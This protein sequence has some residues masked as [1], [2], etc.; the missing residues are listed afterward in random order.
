MKHI[1]LFL[2][3]LLMVALAIVQLPLIKADLGTYKVNTCVNIRVL[4]NCSS[5]NLT[6]VSNRNNT[7]IINK[8]MTNI[9]GQTFNY[10]FCNTSEVDTYTYSWNPSCYDCANGNCGNSFNITPSGFSNLT[11]FYFIILLLGFGIMILG[12]WIQDGWTV[13]LG[14]IGLY[15]VGLLILIQGIDFIKDGFVTMGI[16]SVVLGLAAYISINSAIEILG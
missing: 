4:A 8:A 12:F 6:E 5:V 2:M 7:F 10:T 14:T 16:G 3:L 9:G 15:M 13:I 1:H 11:S